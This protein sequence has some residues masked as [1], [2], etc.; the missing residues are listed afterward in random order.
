MDTH[1]LLGLLLTK[2]AH[3]AALEKYLEVLGLQEARPLYLGSF[4]RELQDLWSP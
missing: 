2:Q 4:L 1:A 3:V